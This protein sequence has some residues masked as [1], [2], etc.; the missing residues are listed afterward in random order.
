MII[1][2]LLIAAIEGTITGWVSWRFE[3]PYV[4]IL[5]G[6]IIQGIGSAGAMPVV[7]PCVGDMFQNEKQ[8]SSALGLIET[9]NTLGKVYHLKGSLFVVCAEF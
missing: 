5:I 8:V 9:S 7:I 6:R 3:N 1:P 2:N 4:W